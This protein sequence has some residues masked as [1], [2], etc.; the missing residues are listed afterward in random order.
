[1]EQQEEK[2]EEDEQNFDLFD[3]KNFENYQKDDLTLALYFLHSNLNLCFQELINRGTWY[4]KKNIQIDKREGGGGGGGGEIL[5]SRAKNDHFYPFD[6]KEYRLQRLGKRDNKDVVNPFPTSVFMLPIAKH[7]IQWA[8]HVLP[9]YCGRGSVHFSKI[10]EFLNIS[11]SVWHRW[12]EREEDFDGIVQIHLSS[13]QAVHMIPLLTKNAKAYGE[14]LRPRAHSAVTLDQLSGVRLL[15]L[16]AATSTTTISN[17]DN[18]A[19]I[20]PFPGEEFFPFPADCP[21]LMINWMKQIWWIC[22]Y[23]AQQKNTTCP[24][25]VYKQPSINWSAPEITLQLKFRSTESW[26]FIDRL[27]TTLLS[28]IRNELPDGFLGIK[29]CSEYFREI[30]NPHV[31]SLSSD[32]PEDVRRK[33]FLFFDTLLET[34]SRTK[35]EKKKEEKEEEKKTAPI[36]PWNDLLTLEAD[37]DNNDDDDNVVLET[38]RRTKKEYQ[39]K[40]NWADMNE[41]EE[42][43][44]E[45]DDT[46]HRQIIEWPKM[47]NSLSDE[48]KNY[49]RT[50]IFKCPGVFKQK[51]PE[52]KS[53]GC[54]TNAP[55]FCAIYEST[56]DTDT[57]PV[58]VFQQIIRSYQRPM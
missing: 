42:E 22:H 23:V 34:L 15:T 44:K 6:F 50:R 7:N 46:Q 40:V 21:P 26:T 24:L 18:N 45:D 2:K 30:I 16:P 47:Y 19:T 35:G 48:E 53:K 4:N 39:P 20:P 32:I 58:H 13:R 54:R 8:Q 1:M 25:V 14:M 52:E 9:Q 36:L 28:K 43:E 55:C 3:A 57:N 33:V 12:R 29:M 49:V 27:F 17:P 38:T 56:S 31:F 37:D 10:L 51:P 41:E 5:F 11:V